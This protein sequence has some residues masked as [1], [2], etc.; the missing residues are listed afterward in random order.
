[1]GSQRTGARSPRCGL[2]AAVLAGALAGSGCAHRAPPSEQPAPAPAAAADPSV[3]RRADADRLKLLEA[4]VERL[5]ADLHAAEQTL[6]AIE[7]GLRDSQTRAEVVSQLAEARIQVDRGGKRAPWRADSVAEA[8]QKLDEAE[9]QLAEGHV[10]SA[11]FFVSRASR[12]AATLQ[13]EADLVARAPLTRSIRASR[14]NLRAEPGTDS[15]VLAVLPADLPVF[16]EA[17]HGEW[18]LI[19]TVS[20][21]VGWVH[22]SLLGEP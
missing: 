15:P 4:E 10:G 3:Y 2:L 22:T 9:R 5:R 18:V 13:A 14:V 20:G 7:S 6:V 21:K 16:P 8:R 11:I 17:E 12:V 1:V 19:R